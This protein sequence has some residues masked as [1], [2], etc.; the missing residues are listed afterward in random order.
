MPKKRP[1][2]AARYFTPLL[3]LILAWAF[4]TR[5]YHLDKPANYIFDEVYHS[6]TAKLIARNDAQAFEWWNPPIEPNTAVD[7]LHPP[8]AKYTQ[9]AS[10]LVF[11]ENAFGWRFSAAITGVL[12]VLV[13]ALLGRQLFASP[14]IGLIA[15]FLTSLDGLILVQSRIAMNDI[16]VTLA[17]LVT[18]L[19]YWQFRQTGDWRRLL[20]TG[21]GAGLAMGSKWSGVFVL[22]LVWL[23][24]VARW[25]EWLKSKD[26]VL[27]RI[28]IL[29]LLPLVLYISSYWLMFA[30][31]KSLI[32]TGNE[33]VSGKCYCSQT[34]SWWVTL[35]GTILPGAT[36]SLAQLEQRG[37]CQRLISHF[38]E[39]HHQIWWYQT[40]LKATHNYQSRPWQWFL[41]LK[42]VW[43]HVEYHDDHHIT[44]IY[45]QGNPWLL[46]TGAGV[47]WLVLISL[48]AVAR[49]QKLATLP[50][51]NWTAV[52]YL[53][54]AYAIVW[55]PWFASPRIMF[56]YHY[57][58]AVPL[59]MLLIAYVGHRWWL[60]TTKWSSRSKQLAHAALWGYLV[61]ALVVFIAFYPNWIGLSVPKWW[62]EHL[63]FAVPSW[64]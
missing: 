44:N 52:A 2:L 56:F 48:L 61:I 47:A 60:Q 4:I 49:G 31:G 13:V 50:R 35:G 41:N 30:Q 55:V 8:L 45:A 37:G 18:L 10:M 38:S 26:E 46:W 19:W 16:H 62:A 28:A 36:D 32:C 59:L 43:F 53:F 21:V 12:V 17:I 34:H 14:A 25:P 64:R 11:G 63:Y 57:T 3:V 27:R 51:A 7:W 58:P 29:G 5:L 22:G 20:L 15:A 40:N 9:A 1:S 42:P 6:V 54:S 33:V 23:W 39:L 24:E